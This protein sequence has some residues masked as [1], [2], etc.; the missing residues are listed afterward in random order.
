M[1]ERGPRVAST[2]RAQPGTSTVHTAGSSVTDPFPG[3]PMQRLECEG[4]ASRA[5]GV[6]M[7][8]ALGRA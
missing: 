5:V 6:C 2:T 4:V 1:R 7:I 8:L 3:R